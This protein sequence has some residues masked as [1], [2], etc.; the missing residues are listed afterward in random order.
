KTI[1]IGYSAPLSGDYARGGED[2]AGQYKPWAKDVNDAGGIMLKKYGAKVAVELI[3]YDDRSQS[4]DSIRLA[5]RLILNDKVDLTLARWGTGAN[6]ATAPTFNKY[7]YPVIHYLAAANKLEQLA[8]RWPYSFWAS[9]QPKPATA[10]LAA[11]VK[12]LTGEGKIKGR[13]AI[14]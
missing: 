10:P 12:K 2:L 9:V 11:M 7:K 8:P 4:E 13:V 1:R 6:L 14:V 3:E 5:E